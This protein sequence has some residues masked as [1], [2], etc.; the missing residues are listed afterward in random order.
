M[1]VPDRLLELENVRV[2]YG[3]IEAVKGISIR[4]DEGELVTLI[5]GNGAGKTT[6]L[7]AISG[8]RRLATGSVSFGGRRIDRLAP[9]KIVEFGVSQAPA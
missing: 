9:H 4:V 3:G 5:G 8:L 6:T 7:N 2:R 1:P